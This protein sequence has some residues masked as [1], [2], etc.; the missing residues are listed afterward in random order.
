M[1]A[2]QGALHRFIAVLLIG[3]LSIAWA[4]SSEENP[5]ISTA[6]DGAK[7]PS[8][9]FTF[10]MTGTRWPGP[11]YPPVI[12]APQSS[13]GL[14]PGV[15]GPTERNGVA[16]AQPASV[17]NTKT[18]CDNTTG[19]P[20]VV[21][22]G[23]KVKTEAD[24]IAGSA[25]GIA[26][27]RTYRSKQTSGRWFGPQWLSNLDH[28]KLAFS[29]ACRVIATGYCMPTTVTFTR[30]DG[31][32]FNYVESNPS[33]D[34]IYYFSVAGAAATG[35]L[36]YIS[37]GTKRWVLNRD[38]QTHTFSTSGNLLRVA[39]QAGATLTFTYTGNDVTQI[40]NGLGQS[41]N[42]TWTA[43]RV[44]QVTDAAGGAWTYAYNGSGLLTSVTSPGPN[45][46]TRQ[47]HYES[48]H[49]SEL[50][51][52][53][54][55]NGVRYS[56]YSYYAD[57]RV[58]E[59]GLA[60]G[61]Q[62]EQ[63]VYGASQTT[64]TDVAGQPT[65]YHFTPI[66]G[67]SKV[68]SVSRAATPSCPAA[69]ASTVYDANGYIDYTF[70]W[71]GNKTDTTYDGAGRLLQITTAAGTPK[72]MTQVHTWTGQDIS[73]TVYRDAANVAYRQVDYT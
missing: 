61:E 48:P 25:Y 45:A 67:E 29:T 8:S 19:N 22:T 37:T 3:A 54:T 59:S 57:K 36:L 21:T 9:R 23:E 32:K 7:N 40:S 18:E 39:D 70:D 11:I 49:G 41:V 69:S 73:R 55:I 30:P 34:G 44:T 65:T 14:S 35:E 64:V 6:Q 13:I 60:G 26:L 24:F 47:Y 1:A 63:F 53:V 15:S 33:D 17:N 20:V 51:T 72:A 4:A 27:A 43:G 38:K 42:L 58:Q 56:T 31:T 68:T 50:L 71:N 46:D 62:R 52:G 66:H 5:R 16:R 10:F 12:A 28:P 2:W